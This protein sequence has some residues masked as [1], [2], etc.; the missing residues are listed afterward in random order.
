[1]DGSSASSLHTQL[2]LINLHIASIREATSQTN[3]FSSPSTMSQ[4]G[5]SVK[6]LPAIFSLSDLLLL[7]KNSSLENPRQLRLSAILA[8]GYE[9]QSSHTQ[10]DVEQAMKILTNILS[11]E[12]DTH[13]VICAAVAIL[14]LSNWM[15]QRANITLQKML[16]NE[17][18][19]TNE[20]YTMH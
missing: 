12:A 14:R 4:S 3:M 16:Y 10:N 5:T 20:N 2:K 17:Q 7:A 13:I 18:V 15:D 11:V 1:M 9:C 19:S 6:D 8:C